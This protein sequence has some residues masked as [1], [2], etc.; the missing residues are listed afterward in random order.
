MDDYVERQ[1]AID[2]VKHAWAKGLEPTQ[3]IEEIP[4]AN[5]RYDMHGTPILRYRPKRYERYE[6]YG[7][8]ENGEMLYL[9]RVL[10]DEKSFVM[11]CPYCGKK[12]CSR[13]I[14]FCPNCGARMDGE[15]RIERGAT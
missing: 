6:E 11:Y 15:P 9:K 10:I 1:A 7:L 14:S 2:A 12:I 5:V 13:F 3:Y 4:A 8:K